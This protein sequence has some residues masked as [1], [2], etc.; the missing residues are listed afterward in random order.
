MSTRTAR[1]VP[2]N[3]KEGG[4]LERVLAAGMARLS[5]AP[6]RT[7]MDFDDLPSAEDVNVYAY[8]QQE[9]EQAAEAHGN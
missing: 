9:E 8:D 7:G 3:T 2:V 5:V 6:A 4:R 1:S